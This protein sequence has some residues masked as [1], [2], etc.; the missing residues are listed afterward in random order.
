MKSTFRVLFYLLQQ[1]LVI[2]SI[3]FTIHFALMQIIENSR[4]TSTSAVNIL[5]GL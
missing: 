2:E 3:W 4:R 1:E 5:L